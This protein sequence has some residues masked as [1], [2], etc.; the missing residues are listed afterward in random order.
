VGGAAVPLGL[1]ESAGTVAQA[2]VA[3]GPEAPQA[4]RR[5][6][7]NGRERER[8][9]QSTLVEAIA[10]AAG[11]NAEGGGQN[12]GEGALRKAVLPGSWASSNW[13]PVLRTWLVQGAAAS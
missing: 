8:Q 10:I 1:L 6:R 3:P 11:F 12:R 7:G 9:R 2:E 5:S 13:E 4:A